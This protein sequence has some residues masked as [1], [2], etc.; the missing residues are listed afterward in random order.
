MLLA[1]VFR[2]GVLRLNRAVSGRSFR[3]GSLL[4]F[5]LAGL[6][7]AG[8]PPLP[9]IN[10]NLIF[11]VTNT[12]F[13]GGALGN[14]VSNSAAA[15][16]AAINTAST[17]SASGATVRIRAVGVNTNYLCGPLRMASHVNLLIDSGTKLQ[18]LPKSSWPST[19][20]NFIN[21]ATL[22]DAE[23]SGS[24]II[25]GQGTNWWYPLASSRP[26]FIE[27]DHCTRVLIQGVTL[28]N[29]PTF[30]IYLKNS[31]TSVTIQGITINTPFDSHNTDGFDISSTNVLIQNSFISTGDDNVEIG[32]S[33]AE[34]TDITISNCTFGT[35]H[36]VSIGSKIGGGVNNLIVSNCSW[37]GTTTGIKIK[38]DRADG[39]LVQN[40]KYCDL[41][42]TNVNFAIAFY[43]DYD[44]ISAP[45]NDFTI[46]PADAAADVDESSTVPVYRNITISNLTAFGNSGIQGP[47]NI[48][49]I[50]Y[51]L[52]EQPVTNVTLT[53]VNILGRGANS[54]FCIYHARNIQ[55]IDS[56][57]TA[58]TT[59]T[60]TL[61]LYD[62]GITITNSAANTN[63]VTLGGLGAPSNTVLA[64]FNGQA[65][66]T[67]TNLD[68]PNPYLTLGGS[69]LAV[70]NLLKLGGAS[71]LNFGV[72][73]NLTEIAV[74]GNLTL[75]G[76]F[77]ITDFGGFTTTNYTLL[78]YGGALTDNGVTIGSTPNT[79][80]TYTVDTNTIG[81]VKLDVTSSSCSVGAAGSISG[82]SSVASG[83]SGVAYSISS[84]SGATTYTWT[85]PTGATIAS[86]QG[87]TSITVNYGC[88][89]VSGN[90]TVTP[91]NGSCSGTSGSLAVT[92][93]GVGATGS[94]SGLSSVASGTNGVAYS[95]SSVSGAT[96]YTW[97]V[98]T[99]ATIA[100]G[101][102]TTS[103]T[104]NYSCS[105]VS[106]SVTVTPSNANG[107]NGSS[108]N[109]SVTV[110]GVGAAGS[111]SGSTSVASGTN[112][113]VYSI[114][115]VGG[116]T[117]YAWTVPT[118][119]TIA[120]GQFTTSITVNYGCSAVSG[121]VT[122][123]PSN[124]S[125][126]GTFSSLSVTV[127]GVGTAGSISGLS[128]VCAGQ[129]GVIY[130][131][132]SVSGATTYTWTVPTGA[133]IASGQGTISITVNYS[134]SA[135][136]GIMMVTPSNGSCNGGSGILPVTVNPT[137]SCTVVP[138]SAAICADGSQTFTVNPSGGSPGYTYLW[139][140]GTT[141][142]SITTN[143]AG[144]YSVTVTDSKGCTTSCSATL[145]VNPPP[146]APTAANDGPIV[147]GNTLNLTASTIADVTYN[148]TGPNSFA[149]TNQNPSI[150]NATSAASG[151]YLV[152]VTDSNGCTSAAGSTIGLVTALRITAITAQGNDIQITWLTTGGTTNAVQATAGTPGY[153]TNFVDVSGPLLILGSGDTSTNYTDSGGA[154]NTP[155]Q[156]YR[157]RLVP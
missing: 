86:G 106:G 21:G 43:M 133:S 25:D 147:E 47:G 146:V 130:S 150:S 81:V 8:T 64:F 12:V 132:S 120:S 2:E 13:A 93:T 30:T 20:S 95:I 55:I 122:V 89:A 82:L 129:T 73:T 114:S 113:V 87:M 116:A 139:S 50:I 83:A 18:M 40:L 70:T 22:T 110:T 38:S 97:T 103:V 46:T 124:G 14:G 104:V 125:C 155:A 115:S 135:V 15:I 138:S 90:V 78:T 45:I 37:N 102:G 54:T 23:I 42:M 65:A 16:Q 33:G 53:K 142:A 28:Q 109:L 6:A 71:T 157:V 49:G 134:G 91:S 69:T 61:T 41:T 5:A 79:N 35:G 77:N 1:R 60:N 48:A 75:G 119:A 72:G 127:T 52:P 74:S 99:G 57:L 153:N 92:V 84:V 143:A 36:G 3:L 123:T 111:I 108:G 152:T 137:P 118:G 31:D 34:A 136:S 105:A 101:Q 80:F 94:I 126:S 156:F 62:A 63:L 26:N 17:A 32:G 39:G 154:T 96:T 112:G 149:S 29:P 7:R 44:V 59:G 144:T 100:S 145:T 85:V 121:N 67:D 128:T 151:S 68:G 11:D 58:P 140:D 131:V 9:I 148:W 117:T 24:G 4:L 98:P 76:T 66:V 107:C 56:N 88:S 19:S 141:G 27:F 51:G 10:T